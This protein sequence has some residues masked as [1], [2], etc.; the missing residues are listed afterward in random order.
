MNDNFNI[1]ENGMIDFY[2][3]WCP[4]CKVMSP[5]IDEI[6]SEGY[7]IQKVDIE[8]NQLMSSYFDIVNIPTFVF[9]KDGKEYDRITGVTHKDKIL[10]VLEKIKD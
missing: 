9:I 2:A 1:P 8:S 4:P 10:S 6:K 7:N 3:D 5:V